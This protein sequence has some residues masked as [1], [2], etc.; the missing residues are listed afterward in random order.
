MSVSIIIPVWQDNPALAGLLENLQ[1]LDPAAAEVIVVDANGDA[2]CQALCQQYQVRWIPSSACRGL[3]LDTGA[4]AAA[5]DVL[6]FVHADSLIHPAAIAEISE[7]MASEAIGGYFRFGFS[8]VNNWRLRTF[9]LLTNWRTRMGVPY[10]DQGIFMSAAA[11]RQAGGF[12]H[13]PLF[14]E[15]R[16]VKRLRRLG[17]FQML[18]QTL[19]TSPRR[20]RRDG[21]WRRTLINRGLALAYVLGVP[22]GRLHNWYIRH[23]RFK[24]ERDGHSAVKASLGP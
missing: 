22:A 12:P 10:G 19:A 7:C 20:W 11:Y 1:Q 2:E 18:Q 24:D 21:W 4:L 17:R 5:G 16:L 14:E 3:Q 13:Q 23:H 9:A 6:W 8:G 15:V